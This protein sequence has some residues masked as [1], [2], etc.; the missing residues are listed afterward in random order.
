MTAKDVQAFVLPAY[1]NEVPRLSAGIMQAFIESEQ[2][3]AK[4]QCA[5]LI[6]S[7]MLFP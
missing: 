1:T 5:C 4:V 2:D 6:A 3:K 7:V